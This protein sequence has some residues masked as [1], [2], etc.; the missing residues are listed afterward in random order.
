MAKRPTPAKAP[1]SSAQT[2]A[3]Q[4]HNAGVSSLE[5]QAKVKVPQAALFTFFSGGWPPYD[6]KTG[7]LAFSQIGD[8]ANCFRVA[9]FLGER[10]SDDEMQ[11]VVEIQPQQPDRIQKID[12][13]FREVES[14]LRFAKRKQKGFSFREVRGVVHEE[15]TTRQ[16]NIQLP[17]PFNDKLG[18]T[19]LRFGL[20]GA[21]RLT[22]LLEN[23]IIEVIDEKRLHLRLATRKFRPAGSGLASIVKQVLG[24]RKDLRKML[25]LKQ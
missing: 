12:L 11:L 14:F 5:I 7:L 18:I 16:A 10:G 17:L 24:C 4:L 3:K 23:I 6:S 15:V 9:F 13:P 1:R 25:E 20:W 2:L 22:S 19:G 8:K 21:V